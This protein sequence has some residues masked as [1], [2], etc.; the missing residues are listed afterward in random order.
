MY[1]AH[2]A[3]GACRYRL[4]ARRGGRRDRWRRS[5]DGRRLGGAPGA[6][7]ASPQRRGR[8]ASGDVTAAPAQAEGCRCR[9]PRRCR[10]ATVAWSCPDRP[11]ADRR[12]CRRAVWQRVSVFGDRP[13]REHRDGGDGS[14]SFVVFPDRDTG[15]KRRLPTGLRRVRWCRSVWPGWSTQQ[16]RCYRS[17]V[18]V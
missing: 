12:E 15:T 16:S 17:G 6:S 1:L 10:S 4:A 3:C 18:G 14:F 9:L 5:G 2:R 7:G 13:G 8:A 11:A